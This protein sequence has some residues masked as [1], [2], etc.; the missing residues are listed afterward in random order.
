MSGKTQIRPFIFRRTLGATGRTPSRLAII[1]LCLASYAVLRLVNPLPLERLRDSSIGFLIEFS[2]NFLTKEASPPPAD[3]VI[4]DIDDV[5]VN[6]YGK[7][8]LPRSE[9]TRL[10][11][12]IDQARPATIGCAC[13]FLGESESA[14][15]DFDRK[16]AL[17]F[18]NG[19]VVLGVAEQRSAA[20]RSALNADWN[21]SRPVVSLGDPNDIRDIPAFTNVTPVNNIFSQVA[22]GVG[23]LALQLSHEGIPRR[24][25]TIV[26]YG[27]QL[28]PSLPVEMLRVGSNEEAMNVKG[29][30]FG[31][32]SIT[33]GNRS[34]PTDS[35][36]AVWFRLHSD[37][38]LI[39][40]SAGDVLAGRADLSDLAGQYVLIG[41]TAT[42]LSSDY[43]AAD[44][45]LLPGL[46]AL[47]FSLNGLLTRHH[48]ELPDR[49]PSMRDFDRA[50][51][52]RIR[53]RDRSVVQGTGFSRPRSSRVRLPVGRIVAHRALRESDRRSGVRDSLPRGRLRRI[54]SQ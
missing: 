15:A 28:I 20:S 47:A 9:I 53:L 14:D 4:V 6:N 40:L 31:V 52:R 27:N 39:K 3:V 41:S 25:P 7:W 22:G 11:D 48:P 16:L 8:P 5:T 44:G 26:L 49:L 24:L 50:R 10:L 38:P 30:R 51:C 29:G 13:V 2:N 17:S 36:G 54:D 42:G 23:F 45:S 32:T 34:I 33:V 37:K 19:R 18:H 21:L 43:V 46:D 12:A 1:L 35:N